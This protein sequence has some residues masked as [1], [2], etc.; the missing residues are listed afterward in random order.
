MRFSEKYQQIYPLK[1]GDHNA[2]VD[3]DSF[4]LGLGHTICFQVALAAL[5]GS[6]ILYVYSGAAAGTKTTA[7]TFN[8]RMSEGIQGAASCDLFGD[9]ST[10]AG[11]T[12]T[13]GTYDNTMVVVELDARTLTDGQ[14]WVTINLSS[15]ASALNAAITGMVERRY[16]A[17]DGP[18]M[19]A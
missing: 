18:T 2:G 14:P 19:A 13:D 6:A 5:T 8:Y 10:S 16:S 12:L 15:A 3:G 7:E 11:L 1:P 9:W 17:H 4:N